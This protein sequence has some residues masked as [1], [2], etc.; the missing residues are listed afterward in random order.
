MTS[1][2]WKYGFSHFKSRAKDL[3]GKGKTSERFRLRAQGDPSF[4]IRRLCG[5]S[6]KLSR[7]RNFMPSPLEQGGRMGFQAAKPSLERL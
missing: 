6:L 7:R 2:E 1:F 5:D 4:G 3:Q